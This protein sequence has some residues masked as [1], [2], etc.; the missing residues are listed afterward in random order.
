V[1][2]YV[3][4][5]MRLLGGHTA[6]RFRYHQIDVESWKMCDLESRNC[7]ER[8]NKAKER[9]SQLL[10]STQVVAR[11]RRSDVLPLDV[12]LDLCAWAM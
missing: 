12:G 4:L 11:T 10:Y 2:R 3:E 7:S 8:D 6:R 9:E 5:E 1:H